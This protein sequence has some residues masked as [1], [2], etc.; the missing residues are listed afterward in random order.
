[1]LPLTDI[2]PESSCPQF[3]SKN[4]SIKLLHYTMVCGFLG[5]NWPISFLFCLLTHFLKS[6]LSLLLSFSLRQYISCVHN[7]HRSSRKRDGSKRWKIFIIFTREK[8]KLLFSDG[9]QGGTTVDSRGADH[10]FLEGTLSAAPMSKNILY[11]IHRNTELGFME[12]SST[13]MLLFCSWA[14]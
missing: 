6:N 8:Y 11:E 12:F 1:M 10:V 3:C 5:L 13:E 14:W 2:G 7:T 9:R 4:K